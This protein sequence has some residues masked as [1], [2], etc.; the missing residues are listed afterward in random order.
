MPAYQG[1][2]N[3]QGARLVNTH[4]TR[5]GEDVIKGDAHTGTLTSRPFVIGAT[6]SVS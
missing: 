2:V 5:Q 3:G 6:I 1:D 4:N